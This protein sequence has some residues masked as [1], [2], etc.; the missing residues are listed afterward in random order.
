MCN[1]LVVERFIANP[2]SRLREEHP[3][4]GLIWFAF[5]DAPTGLVAFIPGYQAKAGL[6]PGLCFLGPSGRTPRPWAPCLEP[7]IKSHW[8]FNGLLGYPEARLR[9]CRSR[10]FVHRAKPDTLRGDRPKV[11]RYEGIVAEGQSDN[12]QHFSAGAPIK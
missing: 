9:R 7:I 2:M 10:S 6:K 4:F 3:I 1:H 8:F 11:G 5:S 12:T